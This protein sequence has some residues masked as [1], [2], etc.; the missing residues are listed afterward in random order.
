MLLHAGLPASPPQVAGASSALVLRAIL[1]AL[2]PSPLRGSGAHAPDPLDLLHQG[3]ER[4]IGA[5]VLDTETA[6]PSS[7]V[8]RVVRRSS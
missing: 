7:T 8:G 6:R 4:V 5:Y 2:Q 1:R 3:A